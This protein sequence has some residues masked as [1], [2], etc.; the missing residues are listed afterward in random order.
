MRHEEQLL[1]GVVLD[2]VSGFPAAIK[3]VAKPSVGQ[4][5]GKKSLAIG[6]LFEVGLLGGRQPPT[7]LPQRSGEETI[8]SPRA[9]DRDASKAA[10]R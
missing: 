9:V 6:R 7:E 10:A 1:P 2:Q 3:K 5:P 8:S 4:H